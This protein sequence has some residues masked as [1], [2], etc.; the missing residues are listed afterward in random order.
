[1]ETAGSGRRR[2]GG[3]GHAAPDGPPSTSTVTSNG[4]D[5]LY[6]LPKASIIVL[7]GKL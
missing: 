7:R 4:P 1:V 5:T 6:Q 2:R 3:T